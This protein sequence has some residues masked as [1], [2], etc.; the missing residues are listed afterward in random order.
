MAIYKLKPACKD[1][2]WGGNKLIKDFHK[3]FDGERLAETWELSCH[4]DGPSTV[5]GTQGMTLSQLISENAGDM[6]G[7]HCK[8]F[9]EFPILVKL[10]DAKDD[11]SIQVHPSNDYALRTE[12]QYGKTEMWYIVDCGPD[13][14]LYYGFEKELSREEFVQHIQNQT[15]QD[16]LHKV[17]VKKGD[18]LFIEAG[19]IHA[20]GKNIVIAEIQQNSN[21]TYRVYDYGRTDSQG[22]HRDLHIEKALAVTKRSPVI[23]QKS[24]SPHIAVCDYFTVD[25]LFLD[26]NHMKKMNGFVGADSFV[27]ILVLEGKGMIWSSDEVMKLQK[28]DSIFLPAN[29]GE[30]EISGNLEALMIRV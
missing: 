28:G 8:A 7:D 1:Y 9:E 2:I 22:R 19:T 6:L 11:L 17:Y 12:G 3:E 24:F 16:V 4:P 26:G 13:A 14:F 18:V 30:I 15:L 21:L 20:I 10:I 5:E 27:N 25:K 23:N 29:S